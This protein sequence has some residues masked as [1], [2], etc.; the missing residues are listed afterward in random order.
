MG[1]PIQN[2]VDLARVRAK[3]A[4][5]L[6]VANGVGAQHTKRIRVRSGDEIFYFIGR[7]CRD[8]KTFHCVL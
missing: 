4:N 2:D 6:L 8:L 3:D 5:V 7:H 1:M